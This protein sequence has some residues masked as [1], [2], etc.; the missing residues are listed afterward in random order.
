MREVIR[1]VLIQVGKDGL[2]GEH[3]FYIVFDTHHDGVTMSNRLRQRY[4]DEMTIVMQHQFWGLRIHS[5]RFE[6]QLSFN[7][8]PE[9]LVVPFDSVKTFV[10]PSV[11]YGIQLTAP[12]MPEG[13]L[14]VGM[15]LPGMS[16]GREDVASG[17]AEEENASLPVIAGQTPSDEDLTPAGE[18]EKTSAEIVELDAFRKQ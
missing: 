15:L 5:D 2:P 10:D 9:R 7:S 12:N 8:I 1:K 16:G 14:Q 6:V 18:P 13:E 4:P 3:H 17:E 11:P